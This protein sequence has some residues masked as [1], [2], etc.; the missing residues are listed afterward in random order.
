MENFFGLSELGFRHLEKNSYPT[1]QKRQA[2]IETSKYV[3]MSLVLVLLVRHFFLEPFKIPTP[4][5]EPTL[6]GDPSCGDFI[7]VNKLYYY[8]H[9]PKRWDVLVFHHPLNPK[10]SF[11][12][13][14]VGLPGEKLQIKNG[15]IYINGVIS[16]KPQ[17]LQESLKQPI[18]N[19]QNI[20]NSWKF[21]NGIWKE[22]GKKLYLQGT[23][24][25]GYKDK[26]IDLYTP[27]S[28]RFFLKRKKPQR[29]TGGIHIVGEISL[30]FTLQS[31][32]KQGNV[33]AQIRTGENRFVLRLQGEE[34]I[35]KSE[36]AWYAGE[37]TKPLS[38]LF[39]TSFLKQGKKH[40]IKIS[41]FDELFQ[42]AVDGIVLFSLDY[43]KNAELTAKN[44]YESSLKIGGE[45]GDFIFED[46][47]VW[48]DLYY[49]DRNLFAKDSEWIIPQGQY[50]VLGDNS[51]QSSDSRD[52][53]KF[54]MVSKKGISWEGDQQSPPKLQKEVYHFIDIYG[55][56]RSID[57]VDI[58]DG[59]VSHVDAPF[60]PKN[61]IFG[62]AF[63]VFWPP[64]RI[65]K[66]Q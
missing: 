12:K 18:F 63:C 43:S 65:K 16:R 47:L 32:K 30:E 56:F 53:K 38:Q 54:S 13:R 57:A 39:G 36:L 10:V 49:V 6:I 46:I 8:I 20:S 4:S 26:I 15:N 62:K 28:D 3:L 64:T 59:I 5:M 42:V 60:V 19:G 55:T 40:S 45:H 66:I 11:I 44:T 17:E 31:L 14:L 34:Q 21:L 7:L 1:C 51:P 33:M 41:N 25:I 27:L 58:K 24:W 37:E 48:R 52:W 61:H 29:E 22:E 50:F 35:D 2:W 23:G 9:E